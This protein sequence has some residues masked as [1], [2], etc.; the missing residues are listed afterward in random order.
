MMLQPYYC[1]RLCGIPINEYDFYNSLLDILGVQPARF[2]ASLCIR[3][4]S[5]QTARHRPVQLSLVLCPRARP[6]AMQCQACPF[7]AAR[8][9]HDSA[10]TSHSPHVQAASLV[11][12]WLLLYSVHH[13]PAG[14]VRSFQCWCSF[15]PQSSWLA[16]YCFVR[17]MHILIYARVF[18][19]ALA[20]VE[21]YVRTLLT[22]AQGRRVYHGRGGAFH[23]RNC[24][25]EWTQQCMHCVGVHASAREAPCTGDVLPH[26]AAARARGRMPRH[27]CVVAAAQLRCDWLFRWRARTRA[28]AARVQCSGPQ[29]SAWTLR[30]PRRTPWYAAPICLGLC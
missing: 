20:R 10:R 2:F 24:R 9:G 28:R 25:R 7:S 17:L 15:D 5:S 1:L 6:T 3:T 8:R 18:P 12:L 16:R 27:L 4:G 13:C 11:S 30:A 22:L 26:R 14:G 21:A 23:A 19:R 29:R